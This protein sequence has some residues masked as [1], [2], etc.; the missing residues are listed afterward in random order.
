MPVAQHTTL[1]VGRVSPDPRNSSRHRHYAG[2]SKIGAGRR[3]G[4][5]GIERILLPAGG[6]RCLY[7]LCQASRHAHVRHSQPATKWRSG[8]LN[9]ASLYQSHTTGPFLGDLS[10][11]GLH[12]VLAQP[13]LANPDIPDI[14]YACFGFTFV[15][16][17]AMILAGAMLERGR[18]WPLHQTQPNLQRE[19]PSK[20]AV[21]MRLMRTSL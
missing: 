10:L 12:N 2:S 6:V 13:S 5:S 16:A 9:R 1:L 14:V 11:A 19:L 20:L 17:T 18:L 15:T 4:C 7:C 21:F 3:G 8:Y